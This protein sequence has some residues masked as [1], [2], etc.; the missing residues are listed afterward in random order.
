M[1]IFENQGKVRAL[2]HVSVG[3]SDIERTRGFYAAV[4]HPLGYKLLYEVKDG[5]SITS[6]GWGLHFPELWTNIPLGGAT[7]QPGVGVHVCFH[8]PSRH[9]VDEFYRAA[10][11]AGGSDNG[12]AGYRTEYDAGYYAAFVVDLDGNKLEAMWFDHRASETR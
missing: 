3:I 12:S 4:L 8:A 5:A 1:E 10:L 6:L 11:S 9:A 7:P 2:Y